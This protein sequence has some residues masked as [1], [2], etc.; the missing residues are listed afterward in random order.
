MRGKRRRSKAKRR[1]ER[2]K[3]E[4]TEEVAEKANAPAVCW[5]HNSA[6]APAPSVTFP[7]K[8]CG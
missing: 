6:H 3:E 7:V 2:R 5:S 1:R 4:A 8:H